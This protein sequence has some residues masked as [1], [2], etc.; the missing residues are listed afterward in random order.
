MK[1]FSLIS[2]RVPK[3]AAGE[4]DGYQHL[5]HKIA[6]SL[7]IL[8]A[9]PRENSADAVLTTMAFIESLLGDG[10]SLHE[11]IAAQYVHTAG[12]LLVGLDRASSGGRRRLS[13]H[14]ES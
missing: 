4:V 5:R 1:L 10:A 3:V 14:M 8:T 12:N 9:A 2:A 13:M 6:E 7:T 11:P